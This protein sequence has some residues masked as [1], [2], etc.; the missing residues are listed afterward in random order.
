[1]IEH[2]FLFGGV[3]RLSYTQHRQL[4]R[5]ISKPMD[6]KGIMGY[7]FRHTM[8]ADLYEETHDA[9]IAAE[10]AGHSKTTITMNRYAHAKNLTPKL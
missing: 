9:N 6:N 2:Y 8:I 3:Q 10:V 5:R 4:M 7:T 1:M